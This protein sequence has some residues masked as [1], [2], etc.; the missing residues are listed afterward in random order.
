M[1]LEDEDL[2]SLGAAHVDRPDRMTR[3]DESFQPGELPKNLPPQEPSIVLEVGYSESQGKLKADAE[4]WLTHAPNTV[5]SA[6]TI[7]INPRSKEVKFERW[8][9]T[10]PR[11]VYQNVILQR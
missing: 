5:R 8:D 9:S 11:M 6:I 4:W 3:V 2:I 7:S 10:P 1:N